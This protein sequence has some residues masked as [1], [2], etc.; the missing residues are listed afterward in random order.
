[1]ERLIW[2]II[3]VL[4]VPVQAQLAFSGTVVDA[5]TGDPLPFVNLGVIDRAIGTVSNEEG[6]F[7]LEFRREQV[8]PEDILRVSSLGYES[9]EVPLLRLEQ[10]T[11]HFT[12]RLKPSPIS[13]NE[14][15]VSTAELFEIEE[16]VGYPNRLG[17][18]IGYWK[19]SVALGGE[20]GSRIRVDKGLRRLNALFFEVLENPSDSVQL[21]VNIYDTEEKS[22]YPGSNLNTSGTSILYTLKK[23]ENLVVI[24]LNASEIWV[25]NDFIV[26]L[27]LL[28]VFGTDRVGLSLP[29]GQYPG[30]ESFRRYTSQDSW[31][32]LD[33]S[34]VGFSVQSTYFTD[35]PRR[36]PKARAVRKRQKNE[37]EI[38]GYV[39]H[40]G[41]PLKEASIRNYTRNETVQTDK[42]GRYTTRIS[43]GDILSVSYPGMLEIVLEVEKPRNFNFQ[44][45]RSR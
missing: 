32:R 22:T 29:A 43:K 1:M 14:V 28:G 31:E 11:K 4:S 17:R 38:S 21:R 7:L 42:W 41:N 34:V 33:Q 15:I 8:Y 6:D 23:G 27:E 35:N 39:F 25:R 36:L 40:A 12:F 19:D 30:G 9:T 45:K 18:G 16:E 37:T 24:D 3:L 26:S 2:T 44:L 5:S 13:L 10:S 20:L